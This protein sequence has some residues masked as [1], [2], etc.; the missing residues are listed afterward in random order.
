MFTSLKD[1]S[2][3]LYGIKFD[4]FEKFQAVEILKIYNGIESLFIISF[5]ILPLSF[6]K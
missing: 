2:K 1:L 6:Y 5:R 3:I 4:Y